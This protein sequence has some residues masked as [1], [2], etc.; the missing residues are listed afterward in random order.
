MLLHVGD[1]R[2]RVIGILG[3]RS[4]QLLEGFLLRL[5]ALDPND[6]IAKR[7]EIAA[8]PRG[9]VT[10]I[11][12]VDLELL[13]G[14]KLRAHLGRQGD[15]GV[16][17]GGNAAGT[18]ERIDLEL[19][20]VQARE[21]IL[22]RICQVLVAGRPWGDEDQ[23]LVAAEGGVGRLTSGGQQRVGDDDA[24]DRQRQDADDRQHLA[25]VSQVKVPQRERISHAR[26]SHDRGSALRNLRM[27][28]PCRSSWISIG[29]TTCWP[30]RSDLSARQWVASWTSDSFPS[31]PST[32]NGRRFLW[33]SCLSWPNSAFSACICMATAPRG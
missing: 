3:Q 14:G 2:T 19:H 31:S 12:G 17:V 23:L 18:V 30:R 7:S 28:S 32:T 9:V 1:Q 10:R 25:L 21:R 27:G 29:P 8:E 4:D 6:E 24:Q 11:G 13:D 5:Q 33:R 22:Q 20:L 16:V 26:Y 15:D